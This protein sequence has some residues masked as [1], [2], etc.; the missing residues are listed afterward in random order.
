MLSFA[1]NTGL[2]KKMTKM[3]AIYH[4]YIVMFLG[5]L[6]SNPWSELAHQVTIFF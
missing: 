6:N 5:S 1:D 2:Q 3:L 4:P